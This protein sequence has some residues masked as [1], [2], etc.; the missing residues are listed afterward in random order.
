MR[1]RSG[2]SEQ[3]ATSDLQLSLGFLVAVSSAYIRTRWPH[4]LTQAD[5]F[6]LRVNFIFHL[7]VFFFVENEIIF[8][9]LQHFK[10]PKRWIKQLRAECVW[11]A[12]DATLP[13]ICVCWCACGPVRWE[14]QVTH[15][16]WAINPYTVWVCTLFSLM[17]LWA[18]RCWC[19]TFTHVRMIL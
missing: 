15:T 12:N 13:L 8:Y 6:S 14:R 3:H 10:T 16:T 19:E 2:Y 1:S 11:A 18:G 7:G 17:N 4:W 9:C 5:M